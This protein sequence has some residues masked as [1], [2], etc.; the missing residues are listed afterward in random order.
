[1]IGVADVQNLYDAKLYVRQRDFVVR[2]EAL[3][4]IMLTL[5]DSEARD[6][7]AYFDERNG[8]VTGELGQ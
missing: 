5:A 6:L 2:A 8:K 4:M 7:R 1:M 3:H